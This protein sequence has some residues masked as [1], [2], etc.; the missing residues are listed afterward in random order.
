M[1]NYNGT[2]HNV[3]KQCDVER[4]ERNTDNSQRAKKLLLNDSNFIL[5]ADE[6]IHSAHACIDFKPYGRNS[7][8]IVEHTCRIPC[9]CIEV[10]MV[11]C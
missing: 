9:S 4:L 10:T 11:R 5:K 3:T 8:I 1:L 7:K 2:S 6:D